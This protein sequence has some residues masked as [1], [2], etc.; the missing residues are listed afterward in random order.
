MGIHRASKILAALAV[1]ISTLLVAEP[2][3]A[4]GNTLSIDPDTT[5]TALGN[6]FTIDVVSSSDVPVSGSQASL[7]FDPSQLQVVSIAKGDDWVGNGAGFAGYPTPANMAVFIANA[8]ANAAG[9]I[10]PIAAFFSDGASNLAAGDYDLYSVTFTT[11]ACGHSSLDLPIAPDAGAMIA[12]GSDTY[13]EAL[14]VSSSSGDVSVTCAGA[15]TQ[16]PTPPSGPGLGQIA[17]ASGSSSGTGTCASTVYV[18]GS[19]LVELAIQK[20]Q[21]GLSSLRPGAVLAIYDTSTAQALQD[22]AYGDI[23][24]AASPRPLTSSESAWAYSWEIG[25]DGAL[26]LYLV[27]KKFSMIGPVAVTDTSTNVWAYDLV[28]FMLSTAGQAAVA[29]VTLQDGSRVFQTVG[30]AATQPIPDY[31]VNLDGAV[32][33]GDLGNLTGRWGNTSACNGWIRADVNNDGAVGLADIGKVTAQWGAI[34]FAAPSPPAQGSPLAFVTASCYSPCGSGGLDTR[35]S[36]GHAVAQLQSMGYVT[37]GGPTSDVTAS[38]AVDFASSRAA[39][40]LIMGHAAP[41]FITTYGDTYGFTE[42]NATSYVGGTAGC[43]YPN[44]CLDGTSLP[45]MR[46]VVF[47]GCNSAA[48]DN[49]VDLIGTASTDGVDSAV[50]F[51][52]EIGFS[53]TTSDQWD[54]SFFSSLGG[55]NTVSGA[56]YTAMLSVGSSNGGDYAGYNSYEY[57]GPSVTI[58]P[59][60]WGN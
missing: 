23:Q 51:N 28:N 41:G 33:L 21:Q 46:L 42:L 50:G 22:L 38:E 2:A 25:T 9:E 52:D 53:S 30:T 32:G 39:V 11:I 44:V 27:V 13:G 59:P 1:V 10:S 57:T 4:A 34:G 15:P 19:Q 12:G 20:A 14:D 56:L 47:Q 43:A 54:Q 7:V 55:G 40:W 48:S 58:A 16:S 17:P 31:D 18:E 29:E 36:A 6:S 49:G 3:L 26:P 5:T 24:V 45:R 35:G 60:S 8:N 37:A